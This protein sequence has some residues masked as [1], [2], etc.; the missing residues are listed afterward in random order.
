MGNYHVLI[1]Y[2]SNVYNL[3]KNPVN[4]LIEYYRYISMVTP[5]QYRLV[6]L[7]LIDNIFERNS[8][9]VKW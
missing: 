1:Q 9:R 3:T 2:I 8:D 5:T 6:H 4:G 7:M